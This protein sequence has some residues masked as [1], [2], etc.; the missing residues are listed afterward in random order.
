MCGTV[1]IQSVFNESLLSCFFGVNNLIIQKCEGCCIWLV[2]MELGADEI[3][4]KTNISVL[5]N[6]QIE[7]SGWKN[8]KY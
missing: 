2:P 5:S 1:I 7:I 3:F 8:V 4:N 6:N